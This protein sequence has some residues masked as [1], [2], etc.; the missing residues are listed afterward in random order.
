MVDLPQ[1]LSPTR[2]SVS[3]RC[4]AKLTPSTALTVPTWRWMTTPFGEREV[5]LEVLDAQD[6]VAP[7]RGDRAHR[8][9]GAVKLGR[10]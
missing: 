5:H 8:R 4:S 9:G 2:P 6:L 3:P 7:G 10:H 1:P